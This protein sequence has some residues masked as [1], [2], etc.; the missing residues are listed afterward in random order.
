MAL[1]N[2]LREARRRMKQTASEVA[3]ATRMKV[4]IV[5]AIENED[6]SKIAAPIYGKGFIRLYAEHVGLEAQPLINEYMER[7]VESKT[8]SLISEESPA[9]EVHSPPEVEAE[10]E[11]PPEEEALDLF[12]R[13]DR[14]PGPRG[15]GRG[16][17][18]ARGTGKPNVRV[19][20]W[21]EMLKPASEYFRRAWLG[22]AARLHPVET[23][24]AEPEA[25]ATPKQPVSGL[26]LRAVSITVGIVVI[27]IFIASGLS[28]CVGGSRIEQGDEIQPE[29]L[30]L[31][32]EPPSP[33]FE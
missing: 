2:Q 27:L 18:I 25:E 26:P 17:R 33:Y 22:L 14:E 5:E 13:I 23:A 24:P 19:P 7:F 11:A 30:R 3:A 1:G 16:M 32:I 31:G 8:P 4:Q 10:P 28:R 20:T 9:G 21:G 29:T 15:E 6:F 12:S